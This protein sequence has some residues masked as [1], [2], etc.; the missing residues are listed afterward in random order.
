VSRQ[1]S[2]QPAAGG[3]KGLQARVVKAAKSYLTQ[4]NAAVKDKDWS[5]F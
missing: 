5:E 4:G 2:A 1:P 3:I